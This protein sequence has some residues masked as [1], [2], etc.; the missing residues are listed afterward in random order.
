[1]FK[2]LHC[3]SLIKDKK[4]HKLIHHPYIL[5]KHKAST[6]LEFIYVILPLS[7]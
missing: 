2:Q 4:N 5:D 1:M 3:I 7:A 6:F